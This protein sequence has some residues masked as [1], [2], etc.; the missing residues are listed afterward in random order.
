[1]ESARAH[2]AERPPGVPPERGRLLRPTDVARRL[3][4]HR[5]RVYRWIESGHLP[6]FQLG[7][8]KYAVRVDERELEDSIYGEDEA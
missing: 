4:V 5:N 6:A 7:G 3:N 2:A 1:M 8:A